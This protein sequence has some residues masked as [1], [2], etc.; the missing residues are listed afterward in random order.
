MGR[1]ERP[2]RAGDLTPVPPDS[3]GRRYTFLTMPD[4][5]RVRLPLYFDAREFGLPGNAETYF[6][7]RLVALFD[8]STD[9]GA[10]LDA[11]GR[12]PYW[13]LIQPT[14]RDLFFGEMV[15]NFIEGL[16]LQGLLPD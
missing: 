13:T 4:G 11:I 10:V 2:T 14:T 6:D 15:P 7:G 5:D 12:I 16:R 9:T 1:A 8:S 3:Q